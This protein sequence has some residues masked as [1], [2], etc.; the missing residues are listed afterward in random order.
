MTI[1]A[2]DAVGSPP[3]RTAAVG[4]PELIPGQWIKPGAV[5]LDAGYNP[6]NVE[7]AAAAERRSLITP[8]PGGV[9]PMTIAV[10]LEQTLDAAIAQ[11]QVE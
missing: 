10:L 4:R 2:T 3:P 5:V 6:G 7:C 8:V 9:G 11:R 1:L